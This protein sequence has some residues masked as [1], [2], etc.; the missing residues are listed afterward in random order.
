MGHTAGSGTHISSQAV[1]EIGETIDFSFE[2]S[3]KRVLR[4]AMRGY[5]SAGFL[6]EV[7]PSTASP[8]IGLWIVTPTGRMVADDAGPMAAD[9]AVAVTNAALTAAGGT[10]GAIEPRGLRTRPASGLLL[11]WSACCAP[12]FNW[13]VLCCGEADACSRARERIR[14]AGMRT[15]D[16]CIVVAPPDGAAVSGAAGAPTLVKA[17]GSETANLIEVFEQV[18]AVGAG[19]RASIPA[20]GRYRRRP[21]G[22]L[23]FRPAGR[24]SYLS[25][26]RHDGGAN[27]FLV[28][29]RSADGELF[30]RA[31]RDA[32]S[33]QS[34]S[35]R[36]CCATWS[37]DRALITAGLWRCAS[38]PCVGSIVGRTLPA[39]RKSR[40]GWSSGWS[41]LAVIAHAVGEFPQSRRRNLVS[42]VSPATL[43]RYRDFSEDSSSTT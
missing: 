29:P 15:I 8:D 19:R 18:A 6:H 13:L 35:R 23:C 31:R 7:L 36:D 10:I 34:N 37:R 21:G 40:S 42:E 39:R 11:C 25:E 17:T 24:S 9:Q 30:H 26:R 43:S 22:N 32:R 38:Q 3:A 12:R 4:M 33:R 5:F 41:K 28:H 16:G 1:Q 2:S 14:E 27:P 20:R